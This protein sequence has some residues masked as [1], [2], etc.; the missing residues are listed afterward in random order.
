MIRTDVHRPSA[1]DPQDYEFVACE[2]IKI[3]DIGD[4]HFIQ[5]ERAAIQRHMARTGGDYSRHQH[6]GNC[7][8]CGASAIYTALFYHR[9]TNS[10]IRTGE[11]CADKLGAEAIELF[12]RRVGEWLEAR[13]G[14]RKAEALLD[15]LGLSQAWAVFLAPPAADNR[16]DREESTVRDIVGRLVAYGNL[17]EA[18]TR[19]LGTLL[20]RIAE[21]PARLARQAAEAEA[22]APVPVTAERIAIRGKVLSLRPAAEDDPFPQTKMLV[23]HSSGFKLWGSL[24]VGLGDV[25]PGAEVE[26]CAK[27]QPSNKDPKFGFFSR[28]TK[29]RKLA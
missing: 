18:Q 26:F 20:Q 12:R 1:I 27:V 17:S 13:A 21:R 14:R 22:A 16:T 15:S 29:A 7:H 19:Y 6:G 4:C 8:I 5:A 24:P 23:Q 10:Y 28:P 25:Q 2:Y 11:T 9:P 3:Q